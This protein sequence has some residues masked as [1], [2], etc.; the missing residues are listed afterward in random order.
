[1]C[2]R[3]ATIVELV[4]GD[5]SIESRAGCLDSI[6]VVNLEEITVCD[7]LNTENYQIKCCD[8]EDMCNGDLEVTIELPT[9]SEGTTTD[10]ESL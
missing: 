10:G 8:S 2:F 9:T 4:S 3:D 7:I 6:D 1:M 5:F